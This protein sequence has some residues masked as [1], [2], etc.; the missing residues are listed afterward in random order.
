MV[1]NNTGKK[2]SVITDELELK[3]GG[4]Y[5][6]L[7]YATLDKKK[8][9]I[10]KI[11]IADNFEKRTEQYH[12]YFPEGV[13]ML[14]FLENPR[15]PIKTRSKTETTI[16]SQYLKIEKFIMNY[17][18]VGGAIRVYSTTRIRNA[19]EKN[20]GA[21]EWFYTGERLIHEAFI[22]AEKKFGGNLKIFYLEGWDETNKK[23]TSI[24]DEYKKDVK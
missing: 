3:G 8:K 14:A 4:M 13:Y 23:F 5:C 19:N 11:G 12:T 21:T 24:N 9:A 1:K 16:K 7:P 15:I 6:Y 20:E 22:E 2:M 10:F 17:L 18:T